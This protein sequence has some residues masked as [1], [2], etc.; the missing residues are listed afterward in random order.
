[1]KYSYVGFGTLW[2]C[3]FAM[4]LMIIDSSQGGV[5]IPKESDW[6]DRGVVLRQGGSGAW[7]KR[8]LHTVAPAEIVKHNGTYFLYYAAANGNRSTDGGPRAR[9]LG[10]ATSTDGINFKKYSGN[11]ILTHQ[12]H[13]NQEE[14][15][16]KVGVHVEPNGEF[17]M[18]YGAIWAKN[19]TTE[20]VDVFTGLA[21]SSNGLTYS[22][23]SG[24]V[25]EPRGK[26]H[27]PFDNFHAPNGTWYVYWKKKED[28]GDMHVYWG[29]TRDNLP[30]EKKM[31]GSNFFPSDLTDLGDGRIAF[32][33]TNRS[34][35]KVEVRTASVD[36]PDQFSAPVV[37][38]TGFNTRLVAVHLDRDV[39][40]W[41]LYY[42]PFSTKNTIRLKT[43][44]M[45]GG[46]G[47]TTPPAAPTGLTAMPVP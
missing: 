19:S 25:R 10:V 4:Y 5:Q 22:K 18:H 42:Q 13:N 47:D 8:F 45:V 35:S 43:A 2:I 26:E 12:P 27:P 31:F 24:Y 28:R 6:T 1:M 41:F 15:V 30:N 46:S 37:V 21:T 29:P 23:A 40:K 33:I 32:F 11:P 7:D 36:T 44:P 17:V 16:G 20:S 38:Y 14:G 3:L 34:A 9:A 39:K